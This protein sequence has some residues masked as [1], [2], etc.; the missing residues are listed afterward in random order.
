MS[1]K[2]L[3]KIKVRKL[4]CIFEKYRKF[5]Q[6]IFHKRKPG[7]RPPLSVRFR[8]APSHCGLSPPAM[9]VRFRSAPSHCGLS[10]YT[11]RYGPLVLCKHNQRSV[12]S[13]AWL[14]AYSMFPSNL[15]LPG[16]RLGKYTARPAEARCFSG[17]SAGWECTLL[18]ELGRP[19]LLMC[20]EM[21][22]IP[23]DIPPF[24]Y[25]CKP[26]D[27]YT[28]WVFGLLTLSRKWSENES[29]QEN[30]KLKKRKFNGKML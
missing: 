3:E 6:L 14:N 30:L 17:F 16:I 28:A 8:F 15:G 4:F 26:N 24:V 12:S 20:W 2:I 10:P 23:N 5:Q 9:P 25:L 19:P 21:L 7:F 13:C 11:G 18:R 1:T 29:P 27:G 22:R